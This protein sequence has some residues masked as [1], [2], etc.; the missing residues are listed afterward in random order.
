MVKI[1]SLK[2]Y[3]DEIDE[4]NGD[5]ECRAWLRQLYDAHAEIS[6]F[7]AG[8]R[9][10]VV[11]NYIGF[12]KGSFNFSFRFRFDDGPDAIIRFPK[13]G[14]SATSL[15][16]EKVANEVRIM[17]YLSQNTTIPVPRV[18]S[19]G[20]TAESPRH[21]GPFIIMDFVEGTVLSNILKQ[22]AEQDQDMVLSSNIDNTVLDK[23]YRQIAGYMLQLSRLSFPRIGSISREHDDSNTWSVTGRPVTYNMNELVTVAGCSEDIFPTSSFRTTSEYF[24]FIAKQHLGHL[25][26]QRNVADNDEIAQARFVARNQFHKLI[27][28]YCIND[29]GPFLLFCDDLRPSNMLIHPETLQITAVLDLEFTNAMPAQFTYD[30]PWWLL[31]SGPDLWFDR[32]AMEEFQLLYEP[33]MEQFIRSLEE[34]ESESMRSTEPRLSTRMRESWASGRFWFNFAARKSF[35]LDTVYWAKLHAGDDLFDPSKEDA[36][37]EMQQFLR[38]KTEQLAAYKNEVDVRF[39]IVREGT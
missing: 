36:H 39:A 26:T 6:A 28:K 12:L 31:L 38:T 32:G 18:R 17:E 30:P 37:A 20:L 10:G 27:S 25:W 19:W 5:E 7:I 3:F 2:S 11:T 24:R 1:S 34:V 13:P 22:P 16:D 4:A 15:R 21:L 23:I 14:H 9:G 8:R 29:T 33:R 35:D